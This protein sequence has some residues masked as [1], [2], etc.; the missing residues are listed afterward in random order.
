MSDLPTSQ[1]NNLA[2]HDAT[3]PST[4]PGAP[5]MPIEAPAERS[6]PTIAHTSSTPEAE[7]I[8]EVIRRGIAPDADPAARSSALD[9]CGRIVQAFGGPMPASPANLA[10]VASAPTMPPPFAMPQGFAPPAPASPLAAAVG[11]LRNL[12]PEQLLDLAI[13]RLRAA[14]PQETTVPETKGIQFQLV[15]LIPA[16]SKP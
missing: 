16:G 13:Q 8:L 12:P 10:P 11:M 7:A 1:D 5:S 9:V 15:P 3:E 2:A 6:P 14:L 4:V